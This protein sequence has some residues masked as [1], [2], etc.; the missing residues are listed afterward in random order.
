LGERD[1]DRPVEQDESDVGAQH[2]PVATQ[3]GE[4]ERRHGERA[5]TESHEHHGAGCPA[6]VEQAA[7]ERP[8]EAEGGGRG[9][10][11]REPGVRPAVMTV[12]AHGK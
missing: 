5:E 6:G 8:G 11:Q 9:D 12:R 1:R 10:S 4:R 7:R 2:V 3:V